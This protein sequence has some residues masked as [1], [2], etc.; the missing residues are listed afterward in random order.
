MGEVED[1]QY[2]EEQIHIHSKYWKGVSGKVMLENHRDECE[3]SS[4]LDNGKPNKCFC[5][6]C[7]WFK[8]M[9]C[10]WKKECNFSEE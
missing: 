5:K 4:C 9:L 7:E 10:E 8:S 2:E 3:C 6:K 1:N